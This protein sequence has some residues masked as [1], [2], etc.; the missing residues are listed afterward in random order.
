[1]GASPGTRSRCC[2]PE[3][4]G[5]AAHRHAARAAESLTSTTRRDFPPHATH[6][7]LSAHGL[8]RLSSTCQH[9]RVPGALGVAGAAAQRAA[10]GAAHRQ[11]PGIASSRPPPGPRLANGAARRWPPTSRALVVDDR[12]IRTAPG[13]SWPGRLTL[14]E[15]R[16]GVP[17]SLA[18]CSDPPAWTHSSA[19]R[20]GASLARDPSQLA[21]VDSPRTV[22]AEGAQNNEGRALGELMVDHLAPAARARTALGAFGKICTAR[23]RSRISSTDP[24]QRRSLIGARPALSMPERS[25]RDHPRGNGDAL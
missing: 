17:G 1:M 4:C 23:S 16:A 25:A 22:R 19:R 6:R 20:T 24:P 7:H 5:L 9:T 21:H 12:E 13:V 10:L 8:G 2:A 11:T 14:T 15:L 18:A 3:S